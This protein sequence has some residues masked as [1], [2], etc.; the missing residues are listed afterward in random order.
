MSGDLVA[1]VSGLSK[2]FYSVR[3][4]KR[5][6]VKAVNRVDLS[7]REGETL[8]LV[9][10][11]GCGKTTLGRLLLRLVDASEGEVRLFGEN[12]LAYNKRE[13]R[14]A[15]KKMQMI[16]QNPYTALNP[17][18]T[19]L[20]SVRAPL[21]VFHWGTTRQKNDRVREVFDLVSMDDDFLNRYPHEFSGGQRQRVVIARALVLQPKFIVCDEPV[22][23]LDVSV[24]AQ[25]LN[26]IQD[27]QSKLGITYLFVSHDLSVVRHISDRIAVMYMGKI[28]EVAKKDELYE[29]PLH[30]YTQ[31]L[32][33]AILIP[34]V[35]V[36]RKRVILQGEVPS[37]LN[38]PS[39]CCFHTRCAYATPECQQTEPALRDLGGRQVACHLRTEADVVYEK[40]Q[41]DADFHI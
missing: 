4:G 19:I 15:R 27:I 20:E 33:S 13:L 40:I 17:R 22:S 41:V 26:L 7:I 14:E 5:R 21:D 39:G 24:R 38:T 35:D 12:I 10:E 25:V 1:E 23:A 3:G 18:M 32:L 31:A 30:P 28:V 34:D 11:S 6:V 2:H 37:P 8:G 29:N 16:Y 36:V 9:G